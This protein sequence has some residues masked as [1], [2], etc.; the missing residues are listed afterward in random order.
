M[1]KLCVFFLPFLFCGSFYAQEIIEED[2]YS[3]ALNEIKV[4]Q[5]FI[6][7]GYDL[8]DN[9]YPLTVVLDADDLFETYVSI[10]KL[11]AKND[12]VPNQIIVGVSQNIAPYRALEYGYDSTNS[13]P[14]QKGMQVFQYI[15]QELVPHFLENYRISDFKTI[16]GQE[17]TAN[18]TNYFLLDK[19]PVFNA[20]INLHPVFAIDMPSYLA[21][22]LTS[23]K[24]KDYFYY[25]SRAQNTPSDTKE[26]MANV[27]AYIAQIENSYFHYK[28]EDF[29][30]S[31][32]LLCIPKGI[33][34]ALGHIFSRYASITD[35]ELNSEIVYLSPLAAMEYLQFKYENI[36]YLFGKEMAIRMEDFIAIESVIIEKENGQHLEKYGEM[37]LDQFPKSPLGNFYIGLYYEKKFAYSKA[38]ISYKK[39]Y[40]K[41]PESSP[42]SIKFYE[43]IKRVTS[44]K[45]NSENN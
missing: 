45:Q 33:A 3:V 34:S 44:A 42:Y 31:S 14:T 43:N 21:T 5:I 6:P 29:E 25:A 32:E 20:Y 19:K 9:N 4:L 38:L 28:F 41:I 40:A 12:K 10:S 37:V 35:N 17:I 11:F 26:R 15:S 27:D 8:S 1:K 30:E 24:G 16:V 2:F 7:E 18:F 23:L 13:Y 22:A 39:G 36:A